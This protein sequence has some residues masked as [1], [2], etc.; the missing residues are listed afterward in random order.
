M[1]RKPY[2]FPGVHVEEVADGKGPIEAVYS[3][4]AAFVGESP[5]PT[6]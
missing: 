2:Q 5:K 1:A 3:S 4:T 6:A